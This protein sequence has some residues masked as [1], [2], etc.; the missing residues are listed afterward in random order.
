MTRAVKGGGGKHSKKSS[1]LGAV[2]SRPLGGRLVACCKVGTVGVV[3]STPRSVVPRASEG[4]PV[5]LS[6]VTEGSVLNTHSYNNGTV[7]NVTRRTPLRI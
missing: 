3:S 2:I 4:D 6:R 5:T 7:L 1:Y